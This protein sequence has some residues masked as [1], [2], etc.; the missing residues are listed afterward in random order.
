M[1]QVLNRAFDI[2]ECIAQDIDKQKGLNEIATT[3]GLNTATCA[4][5]LKT[6]V[7]RGYV[8]QQEYKG[9]YELGPMVFWIAEYGLLNKKI[10]DIAK[11]KVDALSDQL[12]ETCLIVALNRGEKIVLYST[13]GNRAV[14]IN[15]KI[16]ISDDLSTTA[17]GRLLVSQLPD[18]E[19]RELVTKK[20]LTFKRWKKVSNMTNLFEEIEK[21]RNSDYVLNLDVEDVVHLAFPIMI[22]EK[23]VAAL[24]IGLPATRFKG[25]HK[26]EILEAGL[27]VAREISHLL[28]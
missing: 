28:L 1:I 27:R 17:T 8:L 4:N 10:A 23:V 16:M 2:L 19:I 21:V 3:C 12:E 14:Q 22:R 6:L 25:K 5:I 15:P 26:Q 9:K 11:S 18:E 24:G 20:H 13:E 7:N